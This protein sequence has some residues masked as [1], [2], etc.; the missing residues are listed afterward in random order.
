LMPESGGLHW[1][2]LRETLALAAAIWASVSFFQSS[3][4]HKGITKWYDRALH[5]FA[6]ILFSALAVGVLLMLLGKW[7]L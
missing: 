4:G 7:R 3:L 1:S 6:G 5:F 2:V